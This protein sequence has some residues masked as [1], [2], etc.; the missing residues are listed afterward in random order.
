MRVRH[1]HSF[2]Q[3]RQLLRSS[4]LEDLEGRRLGIDAAYWLRTLSCFSDGMAAATGEALGALAACIKGELMH[5][6]KARI[7]PVFVFRGI[8]PAGHHLFSQQQPQHE[9]WSTYYTNGREAAAPLFA[10]SSGSPL[11]PEAERRA[12]KLLQE[13]GCEAMHAAYLAPPQLAYL[14]EMGYLHAVMGP[15]S[16]LLFG[17]SRVVNQ[18]EFAASQFTWIEREELLQALGLTL[19][20]LADSCLLAGTDFCLTFPYLNLAQFHQGTSSF[21]FGSAVEF[22]RQAPLTCYLQHFPNDQMKAEHVDG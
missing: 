14:Q 6:S 4:C 11:P 22:I 12:L 7:V 2:L 15:P 21:S 19:E 18:I 8:E 3:E 1:L 13:L 10:S 5:F 17:V 9:A 20:Q 16:L